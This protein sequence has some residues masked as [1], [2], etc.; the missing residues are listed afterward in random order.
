MLAPDDPSI[1][2][3]HQTLLVRVQG[4]GVMAWAKERLERL[5]GPNL[6][7]V[8]YLCKFCYFTALLTKAQIAQALDLD[9]AELRNLVKGWYDDHRAKGCGTC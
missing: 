7:S 9:R 4:A 6:E 3:L 2:A 1:S 8:T 5:D